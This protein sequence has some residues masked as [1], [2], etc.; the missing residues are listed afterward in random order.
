[1]L[2]QEAS[3]LCREL[4]TAKIFMGRRPGHGLSHP[5][6]FPR[7]LPTIRAASLNSFLPHPASSTAW[8][9]NSSASWE[10]GPFLR[11][12]NN[13]LS[14]IHP[15]NTSPQGLPSPHNSLNGFNTLR[16]SLTPARWTAAPCRS[17]KPG[18]GRIPAVPGFQ[19]SYPRHHDG[20]QTTALPGKTQASDAS[21]TT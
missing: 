2:T 21:G 15:L 17:R 3:S 11:L 9:A 10:A 19:D 1:M 16:P 18:P 14:G 7:E 20:G 13:S 12:H 4:G 8:R 6:A 5:E